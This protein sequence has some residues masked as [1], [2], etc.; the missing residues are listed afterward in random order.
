MKYM[1]DSE[2]FKGKKVTISGSGNVRC[3]NPPHPDLST[4]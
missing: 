4:R 2:G 3:T 1:G